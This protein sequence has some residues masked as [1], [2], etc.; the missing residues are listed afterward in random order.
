MMMILAMTA[1][2]VHFLTLDRLLLAVQQK[3]AILE[4]DNHCPKLVT[5]SVYDTKPFD[6]FSKDCQSIEW[7]VTKVRDVIFKQA[8]IF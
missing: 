5:T 3:P 8:E 4:G 1:M 6:F 2:M 7:I